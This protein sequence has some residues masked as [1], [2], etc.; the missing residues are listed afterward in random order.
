[1]PPETRFI[2]RAACRAA[3]ATTTCGARTSDPEDDAVRPRAAAVLLTPA[4]VGFAAAAGAAPNEALIPLDGDAG[5]FVKE[6]DGSWTSHSAGAPPL[7][8][9]DFT[10]RCSHAPTPESRLLDGGKSAV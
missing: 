2:A 3:A 4:A 5:I 9:R 1:M 6:H 7:V 10:D 8:N